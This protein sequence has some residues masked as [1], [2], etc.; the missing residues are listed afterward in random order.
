VADIADYVRRRAALAGLR[1]RSPFLSLALVELALRLPPELNFDPRWTRSL[2]RESARGL[3]PED[4]RQRVTKTN[5]A[6]LYLSALTNSSSLARLRSL[7]AENPEVAA[8]TDIA[9]VR[10]K[11]LDERPSPAAR[12]SHQW[13][14]EAWHIAG[15]ESW[16]RMLA[17]RADG[18]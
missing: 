1:P 16:L 5:F 15:A 8:F 7:L 9:A 12:G 13:M 17:G 10:R 18:A 4:V 2:V 6:P 14:A 3:L 11:L